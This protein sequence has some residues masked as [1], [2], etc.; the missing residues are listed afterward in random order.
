MKGLPRNITLH[1]TE[2]CN[3]RCKMCYFWGESG[4]YSKNISFSQ[5]KVL[6]FRIVKKLVKDLEHVKPSYSLFGGE[7]YY[8]PILKN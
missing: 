3:L 8:I 4:C 7:P 5:P 6:D 2:N 1:L